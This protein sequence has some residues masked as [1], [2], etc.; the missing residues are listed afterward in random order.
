M[1]CLRRRLYLNDYF[2]CHLIFDEFPD[3][4]FKVLQ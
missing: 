1:N 4:S 2:I 3:E